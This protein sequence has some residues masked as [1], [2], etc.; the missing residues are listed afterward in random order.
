METYMQALLWSL[1][2]PCTLFTGS[3][4]FVQKQPD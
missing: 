1:I 3:G 4:G 2:L